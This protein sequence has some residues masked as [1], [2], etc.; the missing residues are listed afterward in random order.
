MKCEFRLRKQGKGEAPTSFAFALKR[1][2]AR[3]YQ[4]QDSQAREV[5]VI[6]QFLSGLNSIELRR[7]VQFGHPCTL[8]SAVS[9]AEEYEAFSK[10][11]SYRKPIA[12]IDTE[13]TYL[14]EEENVYAATTWNNGRQATNGN[15]SQGFNQKASNQG[16]RSNYRSTSK[17]Y[18]LDETI[19][20]TLKKFSEVTTECMNDM[21]DCTSK[22]ADSARVLNSKH[23]TGTTNTAEKRAHFAANKQSNGC[24]KCGD[25]SH[26]MKDCTKFKQ[27]TNQ[28]SSIEQEN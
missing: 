9:L 15:K 26:Y 6:E 3:A 21:R 24:F 16:F 12:C 5:I 25:I 17:S 19:K 22:L 8:N 14:S 23:A 18:D 7:H 10:S 28:I 11:Y 4:E 13:D 27:S 2:L 20:E 1:L